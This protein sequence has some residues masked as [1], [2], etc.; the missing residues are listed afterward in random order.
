MMLPG[1]IIYDQISVGPFGLTAALPRPA[2]LLPIPD[3]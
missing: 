2:S 3:T 1:F